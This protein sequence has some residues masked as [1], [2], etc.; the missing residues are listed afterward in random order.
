[1]A[2]LMTDPGAVKR[3]PYTRQRATAGSR[4]PFPYGRCLTT[5][6]L[7]DVPVGASLD[8]AR[9]DGR[10]DDRSGRRQAAPLQEASKD[11][12]ARRPRSLAMGQIRE[13]LVRP[14]HP[15]RGRA[16]AAAQFTRKPE[17]PGI[18]QPPARP[19]IIGFQQTSPIGIKK[20]VQSIVLDVFLR[21]QS[22]FPKIALERLD[23]SC[24][25]TGRR[26]P[27]SDY[28]ANSKQ[29][30]QLDQHMRVIR[31]GHRGENAAIAF[32]V[33]RSQDC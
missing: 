31:H 28:L 24:A 25:T 12:Y 17:Q 6:G 30:P 18:R 4:F 23:K 1:M 26:F 11:A 9:V 10:F 8:D 5:P 21:P 22:M 27:T 16:A 32:S 29:T 2:G 7:L 20:H 33:P 19:R 14:F 15:F 3:R 13:F